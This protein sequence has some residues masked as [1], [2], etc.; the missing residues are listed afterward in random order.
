MIAL[1]FTGEHLV[2]VPASYA[3][4]STK[5]FQFP[6]D[7]DD[8]ALLTGLVAH[9]QYADTY[10]GARVDPDHPGPEHG[11]YLRDRISTDSFIRSTVGAA[12]GRIA[13]WSTGCAG[14]S[15]PPADV[16]RF[17]ERDLPPVLSNADATVY[18][19]PDLR[20][21]AAHEWGW[22]VGQ[23]DGFNEFVV[24]DRTCR[25]LTLIVAS[26]D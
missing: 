24:I 13:A 18:E 14:S 9:A 1:E 11:P 6:A 22:V 26:D 23:Q 25:T 2:H 16:D 7:L 5:Q 10:A 4:I 21:T 17:I 19:L 12:R 20:A 15:A 3:W 8:D